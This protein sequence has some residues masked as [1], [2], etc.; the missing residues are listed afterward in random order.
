MMEPFKVAPIRER[1]MA[2]ASCHRAVTITPAIDF[3]SVFMFS[4]KARITLMERTGYS[5]ADK[6]A[7]PCRMDRPRPIKRLYAVSNMPAMTRRYCFFPL[8]TGKIIPIYIANAAQAPK[9]TSNNAFRSGLY[10]PEKPGLP[11]AEAAASSGFWNTPAT[12]IL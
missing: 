9:A 10:E 5:T 6:K 1:A 8:K 3:V 2:R 7:S 11:L 12:P 4:H